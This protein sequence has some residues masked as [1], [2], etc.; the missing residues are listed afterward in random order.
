M[1]F[2]T[3]RVSTKFSNMSNGLKIAKKKSNQSLQG[4]TKVSIISGVTK[5]ADFFKTGP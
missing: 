4:A 2:Y 1:I 3:Y 5:C